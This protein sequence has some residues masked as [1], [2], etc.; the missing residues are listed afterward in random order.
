M[1]G[2]RGGVKTTKTVELVGKNGSF[3]KAEARR[4]GRRENNSGTKACG[5]GDYGG[6]L[7]GR[8]ADRGSEEGAGTGRRHGA[9][10]SVPG[11]QPREG[12][13]RV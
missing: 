11:E 10:S 5:S 1:S 4:T 3:S 7:A 12:W 9:R 8:R 2:G 13:P 6:G